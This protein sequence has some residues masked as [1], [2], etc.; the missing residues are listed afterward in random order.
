MKVK[1]KIEGKGKDLSTVEKYHIYKMNKG[2]L[3]GMW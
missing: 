1:K 2:R 3:W